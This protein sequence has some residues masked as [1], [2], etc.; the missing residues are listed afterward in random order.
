MAGWTEVPIETRPERSRPDP[1]AGAARPDP[2]ASAARPD[3][4][5]GSPRPS[6]AGLEAGWLL[7]G[8]LA[9]SEP[10]GAP[11]VLPS[12]RSRLRWLGRAP[13]QEPNAA[14]L[15][16][17]LEPWP[18]RSWREVRGPHLFAGPTG[19]GK[20]TLLMSVAQALLRRG[21]RV[22]VVA[23]LTPEPAGRNALAGLAAAIGVHI[24]FAEDRARLDAVLAGATPL[25]ALLF[26]TPCLLG[27]HTALQALLHH[28]FLRHPRTVLHLCLSFVHSEE[29]RQRVLQLAAPL[30]FDCIA[31]S[32]LDLADG[33][34]V[35]VPPLA[36]APRRLSF[37]HSSPDPAVA[38]ALVGPEAHATFPA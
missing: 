20:T 38:P 22:R 24:E 26:D 14:L 3:P 21:L 32:H 1:F 12:S 10:V 7:G 37:T 35:R 6:T 25:D 23:L 30:Y 36:S 17:P 15:G 13:R 34:D 8:A 33:I 18:V 16:V 29:T 27:R 9:R 5:L 2:F 28:S 11:L 4:F 19:A 31:L